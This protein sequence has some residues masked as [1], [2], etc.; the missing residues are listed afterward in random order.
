MARQ[1][2]IVDAEHTLEN[3]IN[4]S[5]KLQAIQDDME[6][7]RARLTKIKTDMGAAQYDIRLNEKVG[8][9][10]VLEEKREEL[11]AEITTLSLQS[12]V[13]AKMNMARVDIK[14]KNGEISNM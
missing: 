13:R 1:T 6:E 5:S 2:S 9:G 8:R 7:K 10:K 4:I 12:D 11:N 3:Q 14:T